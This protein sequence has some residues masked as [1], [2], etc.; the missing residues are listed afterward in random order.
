V[1]ST[2]YGFRGFFELKTPQDLFGK[3][4]H[5]YQRLAANPTDSYAAFDFFV[6]ANCL[7]DWTWPSATRDQQRDNRRTETIP[8]ICEH[9]ADGAKHFLL[10]SPHQGV[11]DTERVPGAVYGEMVWGVSRWGMA[12]HLAVQLEPAE[13]TELGKSSFSAVDL[14]ALVL[15]YWE[16]RLGGRS[17]NGP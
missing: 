5:D 10:T 15:S 14:A 17:P 6:T 11:A 2:D 16:R 13:A 3:L 9:L 1:S 8:R 4:Q 12:A 7:V